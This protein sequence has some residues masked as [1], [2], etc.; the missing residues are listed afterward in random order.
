MRKRKLVK[1]LSNESTVSHFANGSFSAFTRADSHKGI[2]R[3]LKAHQLIS[4][5]REWRKLES[6]KINLGKYVCRINH[7]QVVWMSLQNNN[8]FFRIFSA[9]KVQY[10]YANAFT[11]HFWHMRLLSKQKQ[12]WIIN[13][14]TNWFSFCK[15]HTYIFLNIDIWTLDSK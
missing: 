6:L 11:N 3:V 15:C 5:P 1:R 9:F 13:Y 12:S 2:L 7:F 14:K 8:F 4:F 10:Y